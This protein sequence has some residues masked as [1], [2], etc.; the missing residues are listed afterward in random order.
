MKALDIR[1]ISYRP[2]PIQ[3][4]FVCRSNKLELRHRC[5]S[6]VGLVIPS[7]PPLGNGDLMTFHRIHEAQFVFELYRATLVTED[8]DGLFDPLEIHFANSHCVATGTL[9]G[10][11]RRPR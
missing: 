11:I 7:R 1:A 2:H 4:P 10:R 9:G 6:P 8:T 3:S 5:F